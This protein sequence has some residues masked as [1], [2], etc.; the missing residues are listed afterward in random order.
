MKGVIMLDQKEFFKYVEKHIPE[1]M[2][3]KEES[4]LMLKEITKNNQVILHGLALKE[5]RTCSPILYLEPF[6]EEYH[7]GLDIGEI[8]CRIG[9]IFEEQL[10]MDYIQL[11]MEYYNDFEKA[12]E[13]IFFRVVNLEK[14]QELLEDCPIETIED[15]AITYR[16][17]MTRDDEG[18]TSGLI[19]NRDLEQWGITKEELFLLGRENTKRSFPGVII[20]MNEM[21]LDSYGIEV[22]SPSML[23]VAT[24]E[25]KL[26]GASV[27]A[28]DDFL[29]EFAQKEKENLYV[30]PS[31]IHEVLL[32]KESDAIEQVELREMI[33]ETNKNI[34]DAEEVL[35]D[36]LYYYDRE[37]DTL[38]ICEF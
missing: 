21:L 2:T 37:D 3:D 38:S 7:K 16:L 26:N 20:S 5:E 9:H 18:M 35:S 11:P 14:N 8:L 36:S 13:H 12:K 15:L 31:S 33:Q 27:I 10:K 6:F 32:L 1:Y 19:R 23:Y 28:Y 24:N 25:S 34:V 17:M 30:L 22:E 29:Y 4:K